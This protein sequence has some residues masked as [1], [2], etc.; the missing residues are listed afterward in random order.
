MD[1]TLQE[2]DDIIYWDKSNPLY[3]SDLNRMYRD[4]KNCLQMS[5]RPGSCSWHEEDS[6]DYDLSSDGSDWARN[7]F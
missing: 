1:I 6:W 4:L 5:G 2:N 7:C 3:N